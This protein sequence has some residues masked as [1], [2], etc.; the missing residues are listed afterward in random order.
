MKLVNDWMIPAHM[1]FGT[2]TNFLVEIG[3][4]LPAYAAEMLTWDLEFLEIAREIRLDTAPHWAI[5][6]ELIARADAIICRRAVD[7]V[8]K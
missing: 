5:L 4:V 8:V 2:Y 3:Q 7:G 6:S 1:T